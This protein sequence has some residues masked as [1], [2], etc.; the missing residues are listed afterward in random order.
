MIA[1]LA[2]RCYVCLK[3]PVRTIV[4]YGYHRFDTLVMCKL[5]T[6]LCV[7]WIRPAPAH[8]AL[9]RKIYLAQ[10]GTTSR[11]GLVKLSS[12]GQCTPR[13]PIEVSPCTLRFWLASQDHRNL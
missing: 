10:I 13:Y 8:A 5:L 12:R 3:S 2:L 7:Y 6:G 1:G 9:P 11:Q 4:K